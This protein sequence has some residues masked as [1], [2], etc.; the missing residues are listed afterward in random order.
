[1]PQNRGGKRTALITSSE[2]THL[3][4]KRGC[5]SLMQPNLILG[6]LACNRGRDLNS[7]SSKSKLESA[8]VGRSATQRQAIFT[9]PIWWL[10]FWMV[11]GLAKRFAPMVKQFSEADCSL[12]VPCT[13]PDFCTCSNK[14]CDSLP[15]SPLDIGVRGIHASGMLLGWFPAESCSPRGPVPVRR[16]ERSTVCKT[17]MLFF[18]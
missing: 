4:V 5:P 17:A 14:G 12:P 2:L 6:T 9:Q 11:L 8:L 16:T 1:M 15:R 13:C 18:T 3:R 10:P 7:T